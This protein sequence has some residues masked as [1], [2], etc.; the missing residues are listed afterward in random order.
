MLPKKSKHIYNTA[1]SDK[2]KEARVALKDASMKHSARSTRASQDHLELALESCIQTKTEE[3][4]NLHHEYKQAAAWEV[5]R[6]ITNT[7]ATPVVRVK[8][9]S[10][11]RGKSE[12][13]ISLEDT[14]FC[15]KV[16]DDLPIPTG[17]FTMEELQKGLN[18]PNKSKTP[19]PDDI[20]AIIWKNPLFHKQL[21]DFC[22]E[23]MKEFK[24]D[25]LP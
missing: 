17:P 3:L 16:S 13:D 5:L 6:V 22:N 15:N 14:F 1:A 4:D 23:S 8:D 12:Q 25:A 11:L 20:P 18:K 2:V 9:F 10:N 21:L 19:G 24:P 7:K